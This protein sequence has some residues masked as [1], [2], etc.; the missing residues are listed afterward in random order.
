MRRLGPHAPSGARSDARA[1]LITLGL[2]AA[3][4]LAWLAI[5]RA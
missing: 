5:C 4:L 3:L 1:V 2:V